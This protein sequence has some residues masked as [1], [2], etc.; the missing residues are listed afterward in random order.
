M[1]PY[2][3]RKFLSDLILNPKSPWLGYSPNDIVDGQNVTEIKN[4]NI[5]KCC[6]E[7]NVFMT[8]ENE[9]PTLS[10]WP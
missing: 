4:L 9:E 10:L 7:K 6:H 1:K 2:L 5:T 8:L 3:I